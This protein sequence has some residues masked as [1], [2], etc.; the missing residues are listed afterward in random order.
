VFG[1]VTQGFP[2]LLRLTPEG[3]KL[4]TERHFPDRS[5][6]LAALAMAQGR[7]LVPDLDYIEQ[8]IAEETAVAA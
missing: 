6:V 7:A 2:Q 5:P 4:D 3:V 1:V 8:S